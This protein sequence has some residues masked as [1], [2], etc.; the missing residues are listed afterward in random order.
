MVL[1][2]FKTHHSISKSLF[3]L[4]KAK[5]NI[6][7]ES[8]ISLFTLAKLNNMKILR[9]AEDNLSSFY[10]AYTSSLNYNIQLVY[11]LNV[12]I[13]NDLNIE[14]ES[15]STITIWLKNSAAYQDILSI[16]RFINN[17]GYKHPYARIDWKNLNQLM[18]RNLLI[19]IPFYS[20]FLA[21][22]LMKWNVNCLPLIED[23]NPIFLINNQD[24]PFDKVL[25]KEVKKYCQL[26][27]YDFLNSHL[28]YYYADE[29]AESLQVLRCINKRSSFEKPELSHFS[30]NQF[31]F[32][33]FIERYGENF[34]CPS[35]DK[36]FESYVI[37]CLTNGVRLPEVEISKE[38][39]ARFGLS[40]NTDNFTYLSNLVALGLKKKVLENPKKKDKFDEYVIRCKEELDTFRQLHIVDYILLVYDIVKWCD[41]N[42]I[43]VGF[44]RGSACGSLT[45]FLIGITKIDPTLYNLYFSRFI[46]ESRAKFKVIDDIIYLDGKL[47]PDCDLDIDFYNR[48]KV[49]NYLFK[50]YPNKVSKIGTQN[51]LTAKILIKEVSKSILNYSEENAR[52]VA[53]TIDRICGVV[54]N[55][56]KAYKESDSFKRWVDESIDNQKAYKIAK[57][58]E[59]LIKNKSSH[60]SGFAISYDNLNS[61]VPT[62]RTSDGLEL[63]AEYDM[64]NI[65][66][67]VI[68]VDL[69]GLRCVSHINE[70]EKLTSTDSSMI[71]INDESIYNFLNNYDSYHGLFQI[72]SYTNKNICREV[73]PTNIDDIAAILAIARPGALQFSEKYAEFKKTGKYE[74]YDEHLDKIL[75]NTGGSCLFQES[76]M[77]IAH[78]VF[79]LSLVVAEDIRRCVGKKDREEMKK[80]QNIIYS[81]AEKLNLNKETAEKYWRLLSDSASY[82]FNKCLSP[83]TVVEV[84]EGYKM[85]FEINRGDYIK[86]Y[87]I[88]NKQDEFVEVNEIFNS[89]AELYEIELEDGRKLRCSM[90]HKILCDDM[91]MRPLSYILNNKNKIVTD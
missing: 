69:L 11:G 91:T 64:K 6:D 65:A 15:I 82:S 9:I 89:E 7:M 25:E 33:N 62:S 75:V 46:S 26:N 5:D 56:D 42:D 40:E 14:D 18:T 29:H 32:T 81:Q 60:P 86:A 43:A 54:V 83:D 79:G 72:E 80:Y 59:H 45:C 1:P 85:M 3:T 35:F 27:Y 88:I 21:R 70:I 44:G 66:N 55:L 71:D 30:S 28:T 2:I 78:E 68:K 50:K 36:H 20:S 8:T 38:E 74:K 22:N 87:N 17:E 13:V 57:N 23:F 51:T 31:S 24:L 84:E 16:N 37:P 19:T 49:I 63:C 76:L 90:D 77:Q 34:E 53:D 52:I 67:I 12:N 41:C 48:E 10:E 58:L 39:K 61:L 4:D 47:A 73:K